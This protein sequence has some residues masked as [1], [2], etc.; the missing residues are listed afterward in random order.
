MVWLHHIDTIF[1]Q[2]VW[3]FCFGLEMLFEMSLFQPCLLQ[4]T[5]QWTSGPNRSQNQPTAMQCSKRS[6]RTPPFEADLHS[7]NLP[8]HIMHVPL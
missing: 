2:H 4:T 7:L 5:H 6:I 3:V 8:L 1:G